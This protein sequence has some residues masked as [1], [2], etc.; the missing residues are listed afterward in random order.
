MRNPNL[1]VKARIKIKLR[2]TLTSK[3][4]DLAKQITQNS[5]SKDQDPLI[6][7]TKVISVPETPPEPDKLN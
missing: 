3:I 1:L 5:A 2:L 4:E 7:L 6:G